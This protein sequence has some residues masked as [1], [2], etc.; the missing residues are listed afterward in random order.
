M[1][2]SNKRGSRTLLASVLL[3]A[4]G[5]LVL[6]LGLL[7]GSSTTQIADFVRRT[8]ELAATIISWCVFRT[9]SDL[10]KDDE[11]RV[12]LEDRVDMVVGIAMIVS[13]VAMGCLA[14]IG[15]IHPAEKGNV[16]PALIIAALGVISNGIL[17]MNYTVV[18]KKTP[19]DV[20]KA[21]RALYRTKTVVDGCVCC[22][23]AAVMLLTGNVAR[24]A[25]F[26]GGLAVT[27]VLILNGLKLLTRR[28]A[29]RK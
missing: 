2:V 6:G 29:K 10:P 27:A 12:R 23:L 11:K 9:T 26:A 22:A 4:P 28:L 1:D 19:N 5:P 13:G 8:V 18:N 14:V 24:F 15:L 17:A 20:I 7:V 21:Q 25:D 3:S 16:T